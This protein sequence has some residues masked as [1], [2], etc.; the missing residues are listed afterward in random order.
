MR[1]ALFLL[2]LLGGIGSLQAQNPLPLGQLRTDHPGKPIVAEYSHQKVEILVRDGRL[3]I[4]SFEEEQWALLDA[5]APNF[6][7]WTETATPRNRILSMTGYSLIPKNKGFSK[8]KIEPIRYG[9]EEERGIFANDYITHQTRFPELTEGARIHRFLIRE[10]DEPQAVGKLFVGGRLAHENVVWEIQTAIG[11]ELGMVWKNAD[12]LRREPEIEE[13]GD[14]KIYR[15]KFERVPSKVL[16][17]DDAP[18]PLW[19]LPHMVYWIRSYRIDGQKYR[20]LENPADL[21]DWYCTFQKKVDMNP[22]ENIRRV[23][24]SIARVHTGEEERVQ[25][26]FRWVQQHISYIAIVEGDGGFRSQDPSFTCDKRY[27]DCKAMSTLQSSLCAVMGIPLSYAWV[28]TR[29]LPYRY[30]EIPSP[31]VDNHMIGVYEQGGE[32]GCGSMRPTNACPM[33]IRPLLFKARKS[34]SLDGAAVG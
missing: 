30:T 28:G 21:H 29:E 19:E 17:E 10:I 33:A 11:V 3:R 23:A 2:G 15:W 8:Q 4:R 27:G 34:W 14:L 26:A 32:G 18:D 12:G 7:V 6:S 31:V 16:L 22:D 5:S 25:A 13:T 20:I 9:S 1:A 24:D